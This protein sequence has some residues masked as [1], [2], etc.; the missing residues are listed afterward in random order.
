VEVTT[1]IIPGLNDSPEMMHQEAAWL[2]GLD[3]DVTLHVT[4]FHP[5]H[6]MLDRPR[7]PA[8]TVRELADI[9]RQHLSCVCTGNI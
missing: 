1:L 8:S 7:T 4:A 6:R 3:A 2:A 9:A 5:A